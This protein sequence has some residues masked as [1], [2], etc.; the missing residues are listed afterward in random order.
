MAS[1]TDEV[2]VSWTATWGLGANAYNTSLTLDNLKTTFDKVDTSDGNYL[3]RDIL[4]ASI[5]QSLTAPAFGGKWHR[6]PA[7]TDANAD[8]AGLMYY[9]GHNEEF[10]NYRLAAPIPATTRP[11]PPPRGCVSAWPTAVR[12]TTSTMQWTST[13]TPSASRTKT[14]A[15]SLPW[16]PRSP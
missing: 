8:K 13:P 5:N 15:T 10:A 11:D 3:I 2:N 16:L 4:E 6:V 12:M 14:V 1:D 9:V 7:T